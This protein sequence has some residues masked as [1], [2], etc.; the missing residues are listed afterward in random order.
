MSLKSLITNQ[1]PT[2]L[3]FAPKSQNLLFS[4]KSPFLL[5]AFTF[6]SRSMTPPHFC[7]DLCKSSGPVFI[8]QSRFHSLSGFLKSNYCKIT[9]CLCE[10]PFQREVRSL[11]AQ[12]LFLALPHCFVSTVLLVNDCKFLLISQQIIIVDNIVEPRTVC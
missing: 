7:S 6:P 8:L 3:S 12:T 4:V 5:G 11:F 10:Q 1:P 9:T 2:V